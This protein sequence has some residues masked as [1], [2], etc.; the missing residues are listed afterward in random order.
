M[1]MTKTP[2]D[3]HRLSKSYLQ[4]LS[5]SFNDK[6]FDS[7]EL[8]S[9]ELLRCWAEKNVLFIAGN[10]GSAANAIHIANDFNYGIGA[11]GPPPSQ[12]GLFADALSS[13][14]AVITCLANDTV[15]KYFFTATSNKSKAR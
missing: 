4:K 11:C 6:I 7:I 8:L 13:N 5:D 12:T 9:K 10:W 15:L 3:F 2:L 1:T 14:S